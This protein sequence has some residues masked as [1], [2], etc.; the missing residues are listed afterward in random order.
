[1]TRLV[2]HVTDRSLVV[3]DEPESHLHRPPLATFRRVLS[4]LLTDRNGL[5]VMA[6]HSPVVLQEAPASCL[7][8]LRRYGSQLVANR[9]LGRRQ[10]RTVRSFT[11]HADAMPWQ[12]T[13]QNVDEWSADLRAVHGCV[14]F[15]A[16][17]EARR[18]RRRSSHRPQ[19]MDQPLEAG[20]AG[21]RH[22][23]R[24]APLS[25]PHICDRFQA[26]RSAEQ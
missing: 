9:P 22:R 13:P 19:A 5:A 26:H 12:W 3:L 24:R 20:P 1:M 14:R 18:G 11:R 21:V 15:A 8:K 25:K 10:E 2:E 23:L 16:G 4:D 6:T 7:W 17:Q